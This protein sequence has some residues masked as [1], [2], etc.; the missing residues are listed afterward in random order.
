MGTGAEVKTQAAMIAACSQ[1][2]ETKAFVSELERKVGEAFQLFRDP[3]YRY[4]TGLLRNRD[5]AEEMTQEAFLALFGHLKKG[6]SVA[7]Y[8]AWVFRVAHN[9]AINHQKRPSLVEAADEATWE[10]LSRGR[11][12]P[13]PDSEQQLLV[14]EKHKRLQAAMACLSTQEKNCLNLRAEGL[15][16]AE[17]A[18]VLGIR[19]STVETF[20]DRGIKKIA[21]EIHS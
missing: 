14:E 11:V 10:R 9:L 17:I 3:V 12:D 7:N 15:R 4:L 19:I 16:F 18:E 21:D 8:R 5:D 6:K 20:I 1:P 13:F 2:A